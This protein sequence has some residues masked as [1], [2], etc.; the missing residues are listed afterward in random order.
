M[1]ENNATACTTAVGKGLFVEMEA[2]YVAYCPIMLMISEH[3]NIKNIYNNS[4]THILQTYVFFRYIVVHDAVK[5]MKQ[6]NNPVPLT[7]G[8]YQN[9]DLHTLF[10]L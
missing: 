7:S 10:L 1:A 8:S 2:L 4:L 5:Q 3:S 6:A 9:H